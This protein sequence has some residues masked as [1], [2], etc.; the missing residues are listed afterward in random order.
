M[1][2]FR[3]LTAL[4]VIIVFYGCGG[5]ERWS[6]VQDTFLDVGSLPQ[7]MALQTD[8]LVQQQPQRIPNTEQVQKHYIANP[9]ALASQRGA[10]GDP[11]D[12]PTQADSSHAERSEKGALDT[13]RQ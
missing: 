8:Y 1:L 5:D 11:K 3:Y 12:R 2:C 13:H 10:A 7:Q 4:T 9:T 6:A